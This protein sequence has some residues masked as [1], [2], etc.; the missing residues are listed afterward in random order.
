MLHFFFLSQF[1]ETIDGN[2]V[3][4]AFSDN[5]YEN[6]RYKLRHLIYDDSAR[7]CRDDSTTHDDMAV[8]ANRMK[9]FDGIE[10]NIAVRFLFDK[11]FLS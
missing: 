11:L 9:S 7:C 1:L 8:M 2:V 3:R 10:F 5:N 4:Y 6:R